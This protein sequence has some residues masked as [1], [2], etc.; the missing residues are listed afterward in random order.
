MIRTLVFALL[1]LLVP[2]TA[3]AAWQE[4]TTKHFVIYSDDT[5]A[6]ISKFAVSLERYDRAMRIFR[7]V[8]D[9]PVPP[10]DRVTIYVLSSSSSIT[11]LGYEGAA[12]FYLARAG[13]PV[14][15]TIKYGDRPGGSRER[16]KEEYE[17][18]PAVVLRHEYAH[19]FMFGYMLNMF[20]RGALPTWLTE[21][22]AEFHAT[23]IEGE[24][25]SITFG[26]MPGYRA[27]NFLFG[28]AGCNAQKILTSNDLRK[29]TACYYSDLYAYGWLIVDYFTFTPDGPKRMGDYLRAIN[30]GKLPSEAAKGLGDLDE[31]D[32]KLERHLTGRKL[33]AFVVPAEQLKIDPPQIRALTPAQAAM[34]G[35]KMRAK[36]GVEEKE[37]P[38][39]YERAARA[40]APYP[41]DPYAQTVLAEAAFDAKRYDEAEAAGK[42]A[43]AADPKATEAMLYIGQA[44]MARAASAKSTDPAAW[45]EARGWFVKA[46]HNDPDDPRPLMLYYRSFL[47]AGQAPSANALAGLYQAFE[48]APYDRRNVFLAAYAFLTERKLPEARAALATAA[49]NP[50]WPKLRERAGKFMDLIEAGRIEEAEAAL[51]PWARDP[52]YEDP[53]DK[54]KG[55]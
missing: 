49:Y 46:N 29:L 53:A 17:L 41:D 19:H 37:A 2:G 20:R 45:K 51:L 8:P 30:E 9:D 36:A 24:D 44:R 48:F 39:L 32:K 4:A 28:G 26:Q 25:G 50:D 14:A 3:N 40:A 1:L 35:V 21:G 34:I 22:F 52:D 43:F 12:G 7:G 6:R 13:E 15:F 5:P 16:V 10:V 23:A 42:R 47:V 27:G 54:K 18:S 11:S 31:L 33:P 38:A 55:E